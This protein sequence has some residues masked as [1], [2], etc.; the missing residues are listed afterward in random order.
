MALFAMNDDIWP[1]ARRRPPSHASAAAAA[2]NDDDDDKGSPW[3]SS[4]R[5]SWWSRGTLSV[6]G[7]TTQ[8]VC[9]VAM[10]CARLAA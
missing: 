9:L 2:D 1:R 7:A 6:G 5:L 10:A 4:C 8:E 3:A